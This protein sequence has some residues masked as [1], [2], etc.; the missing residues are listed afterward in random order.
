MLRTR[1][2]TATAAIALFAAPA[3]FAQDTG[4]G[5]AAPA[6]TGQTA[7][8]VTNPVEPV[9]EG[10]ETTPVAA[11]TVIDTLKANGQFTTLLAALDAALMVADATATP[12]A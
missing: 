4:M 1:L 11:G 7:P 10:T 9:A 12:E 5:S 8:A 3:A 6:M 2:L